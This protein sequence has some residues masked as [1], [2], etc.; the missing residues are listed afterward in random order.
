MHLSQ[1]HKTV[2][3]V[4]P[5]S[6]SFELDSTIQTIMQQNYVSH[7]ELVFKYG[8][9]PSLV[10]IR[11]H[12]AQ[13][14]Y[15]ATVSPFGLL[16]LSWIYFG[17]WQGSKGDPD[18]VSHTYFKKNYCVMYIKG[19]SSNLSSCVL[20]VSEKSWR[21]IKRKT[22]HRLWVM[23]EANHISRLLVHVN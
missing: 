16:G 20:K 22:I 19:K 7:L 3:H 14:S 12:I 13:S 11:M 4:K 10:R 9:R 15:W 21:F 23:H 1:E 18:T 8:T 6:T 17:E 5:T 2:T